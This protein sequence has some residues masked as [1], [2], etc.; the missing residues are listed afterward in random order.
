MIAFALHLWAPL[1]QVEPSA[2]PPEKVAL[3]FNTASFLAADGAVLTTVMIAALAAGGIFCALSI[4]DWTRQRWGLVFP[5]LMLITALI[6]AVT[7]TTMYFAFAALQ[8]LNFDW[9]WLVVDPAERALLDTSLVVISAVG[10]WIVA[11][12][13]AALLFGTLGVVAL[14]RVARSKRPPPENPEWAA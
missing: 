10:A 7:G 11:A 3:L 13:S 8:E 12:L 6:L 14:V 1:A 9:R 5:I 4:A 2:A